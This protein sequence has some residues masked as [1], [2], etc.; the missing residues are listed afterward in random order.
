MK[1]F[2]F[3]I[4]LALSI[5]VLFYNCGDEGEDL[6]ITPGDSLY[7]YGEECFILDT[8]ANPDTLKPLPGDV[9]GDTIILDTTGSTTNLW[10]IKAKDL[11][12]F[13]YGF[14]DSAI[15][16]M[17]STL[18]LQM[19][20]KVVRAGDVI[21]TWEEEVPATPPFIPNALLIQLIVQEVDTDF[22]LNIIEKG[23]VN[24]DTLYKHLGTWELRN[25][26]D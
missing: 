23:I 11:A 9:C 20:R 21:G 19:E 25:R 22:Y 3:F 4:C 8:S 16:E 10:V 15:V 12:P 18:Q 5:T 1:Q 24:P 2:L 14:L 26:F 6:V 13:M 7:L 17:L